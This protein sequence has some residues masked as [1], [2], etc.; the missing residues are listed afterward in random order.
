MSYSRR[1][2]ADGRSVLI[3]TL[4]EYA[5]FPHVGKSVTNI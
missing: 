2:N 3:D 1:E 5:A 4:F